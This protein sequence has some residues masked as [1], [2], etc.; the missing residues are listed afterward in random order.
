MAQPLAS[1]LTLVWIDDSFRHAIHGL[2]SQDPDRLHRLRTLTETTMDVPQE[3][4][5]EFDLSIPEFELMTSAL[6]YLYRLSR[7]HPDGADQVLHE[8]KLLVESTPE[9]F[10]DVNFPTVQDELSTLLVPRP[11][12][13]LQHQIEQLKRA[14]FPA[15]ERW[16]FSLDMRVSTDLRDDRL[17]LVPVLC[18]RIAFDETIQAGDAISFQLS[19]S[20]L[21]DLEEEISRIKSVIEQAKSA[22]AD[23][24]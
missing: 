5:S 7:E 19:E 18:A 16:G 24:L 23:H 6:A 8:L 20:Q 14:V 10:S 17:Q 1:H 9:E 15:L 4:A 2:L 13:D 11:E 21:Q 22:L 12:L 3:H